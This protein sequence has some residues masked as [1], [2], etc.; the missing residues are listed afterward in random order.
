MEIVY[1]RG[2]CDKKYAKIRRERKDSLVPST[3]FK[4]P[5]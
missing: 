4:H 3:E 1:Q 5:E 2:Q